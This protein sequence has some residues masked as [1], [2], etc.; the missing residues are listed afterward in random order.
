VTLDKHYFVSSF[1]SGLSDELRPMVK[2]LQPP[3]VRQVTEKAC[4]HELL[5]EAFVKKHKIT[6]KGSE[7]S[8]WQ[9]EISR[10]ATY[11]AQRGPMH[12]EHPLIML[13]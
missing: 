8:N 13:P 2:M 6:L 11:Q 5:L 3:F 4:L 1:I 12:L 7:G 10:V 9:G